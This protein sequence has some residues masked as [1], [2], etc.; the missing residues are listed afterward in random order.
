MIEQGIYDPKL[1]TF[2]PKKILDFIIDMF[3]AQSAM[4]KSTVSSHTA[5]ASDFV[6]V[7]DHS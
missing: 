2:S 1:E 7:C 4:Q 6:K 3:S 5:S